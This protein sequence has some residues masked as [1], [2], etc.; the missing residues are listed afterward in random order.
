MIGKKSK[1]RP[2]IIGSPIRSRS[3]SSRLSSSAC[4]SCGPPDSDPHPGSFAPGFL[5]LSSG[6]P[7]AAVSGSPV[8]SQGL[9]CGLPLSDASS[10]DLFPAP[11]PSPSGLPRP[12]DSFV[13][14][15]QGSLSGVGFSRLPSCR[16]TVR[17]SPSYLDFDHRRFQPRL[18]CFVTPSSSFGSL[19]TSGLQASYQPSGA[20][21]S[22]PGSSGFSV[23]NFRSVDSGQIGQFNGG[24]VHQPSGRYS[25]D[26]SVFRDSPS[27]LLVPPREDCSFGI[28]HSGSAEFGRGLPVQ[29]E[30][31]PFGMVPAPLCFST[32]SL[33]QP[34]PPPH[35][36]TCSRPP[37]ATFFLGIVKGRPIPMLGPW[38]RSQSPGQFSSGSRFPRSLSF[39][40]S[41]RRWRWTRP[42]F[43]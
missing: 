38:T 32:D 29:G 20:E 31:S 33:G 7:L 19:V 6:S 4:S 21:G 28:S 24:C 35:P 8:Q 39:R 41:S 42:P 1:N 40:G 16:E 34:P 3:T 22:L 43:F 15:D 11:L 27:S 37:S 14:T 36:W 18:G 17:P 9:G 12:P 25:L 10:P 26:P 2:I 13:S 30:L 5:S 23:S